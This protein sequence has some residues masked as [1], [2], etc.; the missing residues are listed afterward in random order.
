MT[1]MKVA[2][3]TGANKGLGLETARQLAER[4][5]YVLVAARDQV[6]G[7]LAVEQL[8]REGRPAA[9]VPIDMKDPMTFEAAAEGITTGF[10]RL[11]IL[12][13]NAGVLLDRQYAPSETPMEIWR[14][15][16]EVNVF[17]LIGLT[18]A[19]L[20]LLRKSHAGRI[21]NLSSN[22]ASL[23]K[24][25]D[26]NSEIYHVKPTAYDVSK[27]AVNAWT[28]HLAYELR[29]T[30]IKVNAAHPGW[31]KTD[32]GGEQAPMDVTEG[33]ETTIELALLGDDGPTGGFFHRGERI[34]W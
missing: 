32:M 16:F 15:T 14:E 31:V 25:A 19:M 3:V 28:I 29:D 6:K 18:R 24:H 1:E 8:R 30:N 9:F 5:V 26:P 34:P 13:N 7:Q 23:T 10:G 20:P 21:V 27:A 4:G 2:L 17:G 22:L 33:V 11:D 12:I